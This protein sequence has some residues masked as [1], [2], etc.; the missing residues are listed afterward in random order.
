MLPLDV[1]FICRF[2]ERFETFLLLQSVV[3]IVAQLMLLSLCVSLRRKIGLSGRSSSLFDLDSFWN[4]PYF[5]TFLQFVAS[6]A[7]VLSVLTLAFVNQSWFVQFIGTV[8]LGVE[9]TLALPQAYSN[10]ENQ[11]AEGLN[12][13]LIATWF[14]GDAFK[15]FVFISES[16]PL[17]FVA[18][19]IFQLMVDFVI[20]FQL[21][22]YRRGP[23]SRP[24][25]T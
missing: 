23:M 8:A 20:L 17:Q 25:V 11:S 7:G 1:Q 5:T 4:W 10:W 15:T 22:L 3:M 14:A 12:M 2:G 21:A 6:L 13:V 16:A 9:A 19:G 24:Q 18:C